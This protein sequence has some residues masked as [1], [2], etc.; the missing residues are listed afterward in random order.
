MSF[1]SCVREIKLETLSRMT[2]VWRRS[3]RWRWEFTDYMIFAHQEITSCS[4]MFIFILTDQIRCWWWNRNDWWW[5]FKAYCKARFIFFPNDSSLHSHTWQP[6]S[7]PPI[8]CIHADSVIIDNPS[9]C[10]KLCNF[11]PRAM[12][13]LALFI[14]NMTTLRRNIGSV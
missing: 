10:A 7:V 5:P 12:N 6:L 4:H 11:L 8:S 14:K 2:E 3:L 13:I 1:S 9:R